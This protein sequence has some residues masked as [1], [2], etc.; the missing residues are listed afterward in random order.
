MLVDGLRDSAAANRLH[1]FI[2]EVGSADES[3]GSLG[4][5]TEF[6]ALDA[7][8][9]TAVVAIVPDNLAR[10]IDLQEEHMGRAGLPMTG[11][12]ALRCI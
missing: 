7:K 1:A 10:H 11:Q 8:L 2:D 12:H 5:A 3:W 6:G 4:N 9:M